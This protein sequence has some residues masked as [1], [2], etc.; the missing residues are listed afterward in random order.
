MQRVS[1]K[2]TNDR[3]FFLDSVN[4]GLYETVEIQTQTSLNS[5][6]VEWLIRYKL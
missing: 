5:L 4:T 1:I 2:K 6:L 3:S